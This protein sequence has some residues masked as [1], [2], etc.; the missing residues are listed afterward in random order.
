MNSCE[1]EKKRRWRTREDMRK[2]GERKEKKRSDIT[3]RIREE[4]EGWTDGETRRQRRIE[5]DW[6][7]GIWTW[8]DGRRG[9]GGV[10]G[11]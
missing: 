9:I 8:T 10:N 7:G 11:G 6:Y 1:E 4:R 5:E 2:G 3:G